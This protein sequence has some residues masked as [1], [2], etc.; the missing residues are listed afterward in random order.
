MAEEHASTAQERMLWRNFNRGRPEWA[1]IPGPGQES[2]WDYPRPPRLER[3]PQ[4]VRIEFAGVLLADTLRVY[5]VCET[6]SPPAY[7]LPPEGVRMEYLEPAA[8]TSFCEWKG[9]AG[10]WTVRVAERFAEQAAWA[11]P[12]PNAGFE[13]MRGYLAFYAGKM[14]ACFVGEHRVTPQ[15]GEFYGGWIT[16]NIVG[17]FKGAPGTANW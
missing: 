16:P 3:V 9:I 12:E 14:D 13:P 8:G 4:R 1:E 5:R 2:V 15:P 6:A 7:Y 17:P 10:Y 11:Y